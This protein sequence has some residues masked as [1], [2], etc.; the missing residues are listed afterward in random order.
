MANTHSRWRPARTTS[1]RSTVTSVTSSQK[2]ARVTWCLYVDVSKVRE[3][4]RGFLEFMGAQFPQVGNAIKKEKVLSKDTEAA[5]K[6]G[7]E[8][9]L[10]H[11]VPEVTEVRAA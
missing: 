8:G 4:E 10:K 9:L 3:W 7:I 11:Y 1:A 5:L 2:G 6:Q